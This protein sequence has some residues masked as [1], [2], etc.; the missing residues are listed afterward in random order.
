MTRGS[1]VQRRLQ[2]Y[3]SIER[4]QLQSA[5]YARLMTL[6][7]HEYGLRIAYPKT[8]KDRGFFK[9]AFRV[10]MAADRGGEGEDRALQGLHWSH[11]AYHF[12]LG[13]FLVPPPPDFERWYIDGGPAPAEQ[14]PEGPDWER[15]SRALKAAE[16]E[17]TFFSFWTLYDEHLPLARHV[18]KLTF[19]EALRD[20]GVT[21]RPAARAIYDDVVDRAVLPEAVRQHPVYQARADIQGLFA[22]MLGFRAYH[23]KDIAVAWRFG[24]KDPYRGYLA[25]FGIYESDLDRYLA[26]VASFFER[27]SALPRGLNPLACALAEVRLDLQLRVWDV[28]KALRLL[29]AATLPLR[30][31]EEGRAQRAALLGEVEPLLGEL[32]AV[33]AGLSALRLRVHDAEA[34]PRNQALFAQAQALSVQVESVR[35]RLWNWAGS[36]G[37]VGQAVIDEER[38]RELPR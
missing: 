33:R 14:P 27:L 38:V 32:E 31:P 13:N 18:G 7:Q 23:Y 21:T 28:T 35:E 34:T 30:A 22:Y 9:A 6:L 16:N 25:R 8:G 5:T 29:R 19:Y 36:T 10:F 24:A 12:A 17:A 2:G 1:E 15:Y 20:L 4:E 37:L 26:H 11:D 3:S